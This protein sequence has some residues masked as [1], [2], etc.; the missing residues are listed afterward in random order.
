MPLTGMTRLWIYPDQNPNDSP[1]KTKT[2]KLAG[3]GENYD[4]EK[5]GIMK[6]IPF[7]VPCKNKWDEF[8]NGI[9]DSE[10]KLKEI[11]HP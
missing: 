2:Y 8:I 7:T 3:I 1:Q 11:L 9:S 6:I 10:K 5:G 4:G